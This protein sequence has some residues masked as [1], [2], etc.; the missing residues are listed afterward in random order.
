ML[1]PYSRFWLV[2]MAGLLL[3]PAIVHLSSS[4]TT[5]SLEEG[6]KLASL[7]ALPKSRK[8][9]KDWF[10]RFDAYL[11]DHFGF[12]DTV[13]WLHAWLNHAASN[14]TGNASVFR[15]SDDW[16]FY[17]GNSM[18]EQSSGRIIR[19][20]QIEH[21]V[22]VLAEMEAVL[23]ARGSKL[24]VASPPNSA[25][26]YSDKIQG[27]PQPG[28]QT[29]Y[30]LLLSLLRD[31]NITAV[32]LRPV[33][34]EARVHGDT[35]LQHDTHWNARGAVAAFNAIAAAADL[36]GW[37]LNPA[38]AIGP[39]IKLQGGDLARMLGVAAYV[40]EVDHPLTLGGFQRVDHS[41]TPQV[42]ELANGSHSSP[43]ILLLGD[44]F[45]IAYFAPMI[46]ASGG[47]AIWLHHQI[48]G[49]DWQWIEKFKPDQVWYM[50][51]ERYFPCDANRRP[52]GLPA[53]GLVAHEAPVGFRR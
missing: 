2:L 42:Y 15:G 39:E 19:R 17:R 8:E 6:R 40:S 27:W 51:T 29:E 45:T 31:R 52:A 1:L 46:A 7:P 11:N 12:R 22:R 3:S 32:D 4:T 23:S 20:D 49:F 25:T 10:A 34:R 30:D 9:L 38:T 14:V 28:R 18:L 50:P 33:L 35:Y 16:M 5:I 41:I 43:V 44:S 24:I 48:C 47:R 37:R 53:R 21:T 36:T 13:I 26:I